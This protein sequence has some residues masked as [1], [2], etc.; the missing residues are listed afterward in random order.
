MMTASPDAP[1]ARFF[2]RPLSLCS[3]GLL[4]AA[5]DRGYA[6]SLRERSAPFE[7][8]PDAGRPP[9]SRI[10]KQRP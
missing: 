4:R 3:L 6:G 9:D 7:V 2:P 8:L 1:P 10:I 5:G